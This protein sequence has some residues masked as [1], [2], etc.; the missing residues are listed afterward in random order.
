ME[1]CVNKNL[2]MFVMSDLYCSYLGIKEEYKTF[3]M[4]KENKLE[5][6]KDIKKK[7]MNTLNLLEQL[8]YSIEKIGTYFY[9]DMILKIVEYLENIEQIKGKKKYQDLLEQL[10]NHYS[11]FYFEIARNE[12]DVGVKT[13]HSVLENQ[14]SNNDYS[15]ANIEVFNEVFGTKEINNLGYEDKAFVIATYLYLNTKNKRMEREKIKVK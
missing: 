14:I 15:K 2:E 4:Y 9:K 10:G 8:G 13:F 5:N 6:I 12:L 11:H 1:Q 7:E 3:L